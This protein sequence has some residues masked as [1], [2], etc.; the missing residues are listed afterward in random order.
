MERRPSRTAAGLRSVDFWP[1]DREP[2]SRAISAGRIALPHRDRPQRS[3]GHPGYFARIRAARIVIYAS[4]V[5]DR[6]VVISIVD[7]RCVA[8][9]GGIV[10]DRNVLL[11]ADVIV[12]DMRAG[13]ILLRNEAPIVRWRIVAATNRYRHTYTG[14]Q[15]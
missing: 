6:R 5:D 4:I 1:V 11:L 10:D 13:Y 9:N 8:D 12:V 3:T 2:P 15:R 14:T 7:D